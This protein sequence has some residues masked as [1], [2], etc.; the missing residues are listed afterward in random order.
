M[1][2]QDY[3]KEIRSYFAA[4]TVEYD[5]FREAGAGG[6]GGIIKAK[7]SHLLKNEKVKSTLDKLRE[8]MVLD[9]LAALGGGGGRPERVAPSERDWRRKVQTMN[10]K[11]KQFPQLT[12]KAK[13]SHTKKSGRCVVA[14]QKILPGICTCNC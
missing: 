4:C 9:K 2:F 8:G 12:Q 7:L 6:S 11:S 3:Y 1:K 5:K 13:V 10:A 14:T